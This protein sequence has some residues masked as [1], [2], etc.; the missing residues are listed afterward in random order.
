ME[1]KIV[2]IIGKPGLYRLLS[3]GRTTVIVESLDAQKK[4]FSVGLH[5][6]VTS[7]SDISMYTT[8]E[9][10]P[11]YKVYRTIFEKTEGKPIDIVP[12]KASNDELY[13]FLGSVLPTFDRDRVHP[14]DIRKLI[15]WFN[16]LVNNGITDFPLDEEEQSQ[17]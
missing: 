4:R 8:E 2:A 5:D 16:I 6:R 17:E 14:S 10:T 13:D 11:L 9:D 12:S 1:Q 3:R 15:Q 7:L